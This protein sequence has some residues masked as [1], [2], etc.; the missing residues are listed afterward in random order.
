MFPVHAD[1]TSYGYSIRSCSAPVVVMRTTSFSVSRDVA[2][3]IC[4]IW[5]F[6]ILGMQWWGFVLLVV[7]TVWGCV[8]GC[9]WRRAARRRLPLPP[10]MQVQDLNVCSKAC[11]NQI[12]CYGCCP[13]GGFGGRPDERQPLMHG[14]SQSNR[15]C[16]PQSATSPQPALRQYD[17]NLPL[18]LGWEAVRTSDNSTYF[19]NHA[20]QS[21]HWEA[22]VPA[23]S[24]QPAL[25]QY[26]PNLPLGWEAMRTSNNGVYFVNHADQSTHWEAPEDLGAL[27]ST[28][29]LPLYQANPPLNSSTRSNSGNVAVLRPDAEPAALASA[30]GQDSVA[31]NLGDTSAGATYV[32]SINKGPSGLAGLTM[33]SNEFGRSRTC[34]TSVSVGGATEAALAK[35]QLDVA[36]GL[37]IVDIN[38]VDT[39]QM[40]Q[41]ECFDEL[42][43]SNVVLMTLKTGASHVTHSSA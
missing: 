17:P 18:P 13:D 27:A 21:T 8:S 5:A 3:S 35:A 20:D 28:P 32:I 31:S 37:Q 4:S 42:I 10:S 29:E 11:V 36:D 33:E 7:F 23:I 43:K 15:A 39:S 38:G 34:I 1:T 16:N 6:Y 41:R 25:R 24:P 19:V 12:A 30:P 2:D 22:P 40:R 14:I 26:D 9:R